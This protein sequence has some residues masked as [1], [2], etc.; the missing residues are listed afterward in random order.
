MSDYG[1]IPDE[2]LREGTYRDQAH[3]DE[4]HDDDDES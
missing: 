2:I 3:V 1:E 4:D